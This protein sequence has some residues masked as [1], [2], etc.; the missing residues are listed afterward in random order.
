MGG[1]RTFGD[2]NAVSGVD[3]LVYIFVITRSP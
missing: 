2:G 1:I 3:S